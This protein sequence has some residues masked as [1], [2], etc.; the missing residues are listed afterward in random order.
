MY[1]SNLQ[2]QSVYVYFAIREKKYKGFISYWIPAFAGM[3]IGV[4]V[5]G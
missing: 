5:Q 2:L 4:R 1:L 3:T